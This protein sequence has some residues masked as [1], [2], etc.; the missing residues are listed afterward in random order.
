MNFWKHLQ[1][2]LLFEKICL[3][4]IDLQMSGEQ[5]DTS[6][7]IENGEWQLTSE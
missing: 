3:S 6:D 2:I 1:I 7:Y 4:Q 5:G